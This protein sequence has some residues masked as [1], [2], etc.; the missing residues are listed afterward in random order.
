MP[1]CQ[2][3]LLVSCQSLSSFALVSQLKL[4]GGSLQ[5]KIIKLTKQT[6]VIMVLFK[7]T[8]VTD[9]VTKLRKVAKVTRVTKVMR[10]SGH[11][12]SKQGLRFNQPTASGHQTTTNQLCK[13]Q[14]THH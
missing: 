12:P 10:V 9:L 3:S 6:T 2:K 4:D 14:S 8:R 11:R 7:V 1:A 13:L 5:E